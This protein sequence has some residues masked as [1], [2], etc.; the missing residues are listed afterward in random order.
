MMPSSRATKLFSTSALVAV[1]LV[2]WLAFAPPQLGGSTSYVITHGNSMEPRI[3][4]GDLVLLRRGSYGP[5]VVVG[6]RSDS[7]QQVVMHRIVEETPEGFVTKGDNNTWLDTDRPTAADVIGREWLHLPGAGKWIARLRSPAVAAVVIGGAA[8]AFFVGDKGKKRRTRKGRLP[9]VP[10]IK[11]TELSADTRRLLAGAGA[12]L[13][14]FALLGA[15]AFSQPKVAPV[16]AD[17]AFEHVGSFDFD[18][19]VEANAVYP[20]GKVEPGRPIFLKLVDRLDVR[21]D[22]TLS[23]A[24]ESAVEGE[25]MMFARVVGATGWRKA[26]PVAPAKA[27]SGERVQLNGVLDLRAIK[28]LS[29]EVQAV[30]GLSETNQTVQLIPRIDIA[31]EI[32]GTRFEER[33]APE[34]AFEMDAYQLRLAAGPE[35]EVG[36]EGT[37]STS[38][39]RQTEPGEVSV[40]ELRSRALGFLG[41]SVRVETLRSVS[42]AGLLVALFASGVIWTRAARSGQL[43][44]VGSIGARYGQWLVPVERVPVKAQRSAVRLAGIEPLIRLAELYER[45]VL[46]GEAKGVHIYFLEEDGVV[47][48][49]RTEGAPPAPATPAPESKPVSADKGSIELREERRKQEAA[50]LRK[51]LRA[52]ETKVLRSPAGRDEGE[53]APS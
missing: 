30:T 46:H 47:Y 52:I 11:P 39:L 49:Y 21:F 43:D 28:G 51:E 5:G 50:R 7:L 13:L 37:S 6:Y 42:L 25:A 33:F 36:L 18:A 14:L 31:G 27:F 32:A 3:E 38:A 41:I 17:A 4:E 34:L 35:G 44:E 10:L 12:A 19:K 45:M 8:M 40:S 15:I 16:A 48:S 26:I 22:Y 9:Q 20:T 24:T 23:S 53:P 2:A 1:V 29:S